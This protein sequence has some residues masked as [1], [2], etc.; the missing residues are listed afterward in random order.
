MYG[1]KKTIYVPIQLRRSC[2]FSSLDADDNITKAIYDRHLVDAE[3]YLYES[4]IE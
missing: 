4:M 1:S 2:L 3:A